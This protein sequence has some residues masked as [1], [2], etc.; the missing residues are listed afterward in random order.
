[1]I[2]P[3]CGSDVLSVS[4]EAST[5]FVGG[6]WSDPFW[7]WW[8]V[9]MLWLAFKLGSRVRRGVRWMRQKFNQSAVDQT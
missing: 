6:K 7:Q 8:D 3:A 2:A 5:A 4:G 9:I 1:M